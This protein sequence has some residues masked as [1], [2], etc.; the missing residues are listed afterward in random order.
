MTT[1]RTLGWFVA[2]NDM[3]S[4]VI[5]RRKVRKGLRMRGGRPDIG[6][7]GTRWSEIGVRSELRPDWRF[8]DFATWVCIM[9][10]YIAVKTLHSAYCTP[11]LWYA[12]PRNFS[13]N[14]SAA[15]ICYEYLLRIFYSGIY[16][17]CMASSCSGLLT[18]QN[19]SP[20]WSTTFLHKVCPWDLPVACS[21][22]LEG[23]SDLL[24][25][26]RIVAFVATSGFWHD[27]MSRVMH[28]CCVISAV[29]I[30]ISIS[31]KTQPRQKMSTGNPRVSCLNSFGGP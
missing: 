23:H 10:C 1:G 3:V 17:S 12:T 15:T 20:K 22:F 27:T 24:G 13:Y 31:N 25:G 18:Q 11:H 5:E 9:Q 28:L 26:D 29:E 21:V 2:T 30:E 6:G 7:F 16:R 8:L 4:A 14:R 19:C